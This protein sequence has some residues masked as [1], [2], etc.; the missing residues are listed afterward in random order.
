MIIPVKRPRV[1]AIEAGVVSGSIFMTEL[2]TVPTSK[3]TVAA[4][5]MSIII[6]KKKIFFS[7][8]TY[9]SDQH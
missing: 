6:K 7:N 9:K 2:T 8:A 5:I 1:A 3:E 4:I